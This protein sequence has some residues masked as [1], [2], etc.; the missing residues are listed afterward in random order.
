MN[1]NV[2]L[3]EAIRLG[4][5][6]GPQAIGLF[7]CEASVVRH[8]CA[9]GAALAAVGKTRASALCD[10]FDTGGVGGR[11]LCPVDACGDLRL[12]GGLITHL[13]DAHLWTRERIA[14]HVE[15]LEL[16]LN[17][18]VNKNESYDDKTSE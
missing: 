15:R 9:Y 12:I 14:D 13:N 18:P 3:S 7:E 16:S 10:A 4:S 1:T 6:L 8:L 11:F 17:Q 2:T 5:M